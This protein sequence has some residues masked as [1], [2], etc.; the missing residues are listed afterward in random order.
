MSL[1]SAPNDTYTR[2]AQLRAELWRE[3]GF[4]LLQDLRVSLFDFDRRQEHQDSLLALSEANRLI[5]ELGAIEPRWLDFSVAIFVALLEYNPT[6]KSIQ[7]KKLLKK[8][9][10]TLEKIKNG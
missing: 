4:D 6:K 8:F 7:S 9:T 1:G 10:E 3:H 2:T 5:I